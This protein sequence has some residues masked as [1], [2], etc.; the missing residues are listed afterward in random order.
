MTEGQKYKV[1]ETIK[2][3]D[4]LKD[5]YICTPYAGLFGNTTIAAVVEEMIADPHS[6]YVV[7]DL[8]VLTD[9]KKKKVKRALKRL[10]E[11]R[12]VITKNNKEFNTNHDS[13]IVAALTF[14]AYGLVDDIY[15]TD[16]MLVAIK[17][18]LS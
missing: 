10:I 1:K 5:K 15:G 9:R 7:K 17:D 12:V 18:Y 14:L 3:P 13:N 11:L 2:L 8:V 6:T 4:L 16:T